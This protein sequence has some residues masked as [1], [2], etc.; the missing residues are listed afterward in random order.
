MIKLYFIGVYIFPFLE[1]TL[2]TVQVNMLINN[3]NV[4]AMK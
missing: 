2:T 4:I 1:G 3:D